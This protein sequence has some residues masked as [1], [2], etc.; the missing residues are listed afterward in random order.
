M[1]NPFRRR[2]TPPVPRLRDAADAF[3]SSS[4]RRQITEQRLDA[5]RLVLRDFAAWAGPDRRL[6][7][8]RTD[9]ADAYAR[10]IPHYLAAATYADKLS[11]LRT[12]W[13]TL[14]PHAANPWIGI[15]RRP[16]DSRPREPLTRAEI[17]AVVVMAA[18]HGR[19]GRELATLI[20]VGAW[21]G[22]R[23]GD[24]V[25]LQWAAVGAQTITVRTRKTGAEITIPIL[26]PL[27]AALDA[28]RAEQAPKQLGAAV[29]PHLV[30]S[31]ERYHGHTGNVAQQVCL[32]MRRCGL[33]TSYAHD[34]TARRR[35]L[36]G[37]HSLRHTYVTALLEAGIPMDIVSALVGHATIQMTAHYTHARLP[38]ILDA[39]TRAGL[40]AAPPSG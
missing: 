25:R 6:T 20:Q 29:F 26:A 2:S 24:A 8:I 19:N 32:C 38:Y 34:H 14:L 28:W 36:R 22:L 10:R 39:L 35:P 18:R 23:L 37:Y 11:A 15:Q 1:H 9:E 30:A 27:R 12:T 5:Y 40:I 16:A 21:T 13:A 17:D 3:A 7:D 31:V 4:R 33:E